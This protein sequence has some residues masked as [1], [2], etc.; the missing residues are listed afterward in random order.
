MKIFAK[1]II[2]IGMV[3]LI[4]S[5]SIAIE[6]AAQSP[7]NMDDWLSDF[8]KQIKTNWKPDK[9]IDGNLNTVIEFYVTKDGKIEAPKIKQSSGN[10]RYDNYAKDVLISSQPYTK[11]PQKEEKVLISFTF[12]FNDYNQIDENTVYKDWWKDFQHQVQANWHPTKTSSTKKAYKT[13]V[14]FFISDKGEVE[15]CKIT[16]SSGSSGFDKYAVKTLMSGQPYKPMPKTVSEKVPIKFTFTFNPDNTPDVHNYFD[17]AIIGQ[18]ERRWRPKINKDE[19]ER[20]EISLKIIVS[21]GGFVESCEV[22]KSSGDLYNDELAVKAVY[23]ASPFKRV[24]DE[25]LDY[26]KNVTSGIVT[27]RR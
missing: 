1:P 7:Q 6:N 4:M 17:E 3:M 8:R 14:S 2:F 24:E 23:K 11:L 12:K 13:T 9:N 25:Y 20:N 16:K 27:L 15:H 26:G 18:I 19:N 5:P 21:K 10:S 22:V